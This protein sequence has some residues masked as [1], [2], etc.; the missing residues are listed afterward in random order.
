[1]L[2]H[3]IASLPVVVLILISSKIPERVKV[4]TT[5]VIIIRAV[6]ISNRIVVLFLVS[7]P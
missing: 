1:M 4:A 6:V 3:V 7:L 2:D 5:V